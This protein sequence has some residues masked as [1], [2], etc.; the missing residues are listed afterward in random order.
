MAT[1]KTRY[2]KR[3]KKTRRKRHLKAKLKPFHYLLNDAKNSPK[4]A[5]HLSRNK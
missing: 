5:L 3:E 2:E 4:F 1:T